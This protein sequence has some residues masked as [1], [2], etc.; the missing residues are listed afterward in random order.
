MSDRF[1]QTSSF[2]NRP[3]STPHQPF[4]F[5]NSA[6]YVQF[7]TT[8]RVF[9]PQHPLAFPNFEFSTK[10]INYIFSPLFNNRLSKCD[11]GVESTDKAVS[12]DSSSCEH[13]CQVILKSSHE[14]E[15][16]WTEKKMKR[17]DRGNTLCSIFLSQTSWERGWCYDPLVAF[18][19][20]TQ[21]VQSVCLGKKPGQCQRGNNRPSLHWKLGFFKTSSKQEQ[22]FICYYTL[23][24]YIY[25]RLISGGI[26]L[27][28]SILQNYVLYSEILLWNIEAL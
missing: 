11:L 18:H 28:W 4:Q 19:F 9:H 23:L 6:I 1:E 13:L 8:Q 16:Y 27:G 15:S 17:K 20:L 26:F 12:R 24:L 2:K 21:L 14:W 7:F 25:K 5:R 3:S 10:I 22:L